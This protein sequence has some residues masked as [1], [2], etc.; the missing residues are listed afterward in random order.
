[1]GNQ[2]G[3]LGPYDS[4]HPNASRWDARYR[5]RGSDYGS[6]RPLLQERLELLP[7][8]G[9][10]LD[11]AAGQG[12]NG[13]ALAERGLTVFAIDVSLVAMRTAAQRARA[14]SAPLY[15]VVADLTTI[16]L[17]ERWFDVILNF[18]FL[19]RALFAVYRRTL[20]PGGLLFFETFVR[21]SDEYPAAD[22]FLEPDELLTNFGDYEILHL[23]QIEHRDEGG[24][25]VR[26]SER[27]I[28]R[29]PEDG[30]ES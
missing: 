12:R 20:K 1:M 6:V 27:L 22:Y 15:P 29:K 11:A 8:E 24:K 14:Q 4:K 18:H 23:D 16:R 26:R 2:T 13:L 17:P 5:D 21:S 7:G 9:R 10:A 3:E 25:L 30:R 28:A 19:E